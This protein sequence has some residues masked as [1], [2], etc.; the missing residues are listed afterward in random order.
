MILLLSAI[1]LAR[2][3]KPRSELAIESAFPRERAAQCA[4]SSMLSAAYDGTNSIVHLLPED[5]DA[6]VA[7]GCHP[8][9]GRRLTLVYRAGGSQISVLLVEVS[10]PSE[11]IL[12]A[13]DCAPVHEW[14][15]GGARWAAMDAGWRTPIL[16]H[17]V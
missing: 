15:S 7:T 8:Q 17:A 5:R 1:A 10:R 9:V 4:L 12:A 6:I 3:P 2:W 13:Y 11:D 16:F 14:M